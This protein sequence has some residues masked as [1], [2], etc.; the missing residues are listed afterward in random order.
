MS[1]NIL[2][3][4]DDVASLEL[5]SEVLRSV[6]AEVTAV[7]DAV[8]ASAFIGKANFDGIFLDLMMPKIDGLT[9]AKMIRKSQRNRGTPIVIVTGRDDKS[10]VKDSFAAGATFYLQKPI[11]RHK[12]I[13]LFKVTRGSMFQ[14]RRKFLRV[15]LRTV[16]VCQ[17]D[18]EAIR[19]QSCNLS[20]SGMLFEAGRYLQP[21]TTVR[22][23]FRLPAGGP[24]IHVQAV[25]ARADEKQRAGLRFLSMN[26]E[27]QQRIS[28]LVS[29]FEGDESR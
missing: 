9:L 15:P 29:D 22:L 6:N 27:A 4:E 17:L 23:S 1:L 5:I 2:V 3:V 24:E 20:E 13:N 21:G 14:N 26:K 28:Q 12:L 11:D 18:A 19:G 16:V 8:N 10:T 7:S 25:I